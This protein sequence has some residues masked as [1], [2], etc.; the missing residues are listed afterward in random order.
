MVSFANHHDQLM[1]IE[2]EPLPL[3]G[4]IALW[5][6][7]PTFQLSPQESDNRKLTHYSYCNQ[8]VQDGVQMIECR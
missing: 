5:N 7:G 4:P 6:R 2:T 1:Q 3:P 8:L